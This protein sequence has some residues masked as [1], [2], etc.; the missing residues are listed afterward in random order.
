MLLGER[1]LDEP[2]LDLFVL[3]TAQ[4]DAT[5]GLE[6]TARAADLL[7][8]GDG[9][10][11]RL[12]VDDEAEVGFVV[13]HPE[14]SGRDERLDLVGLEFAFGFDAGLVVERSEVG[15]DL[16]ALRREPGRHVLD[17]AHGEAVD[18]AGAVELGE[19][20]GEPG[21]A[22]GL[23]VEADRAERETLTAQRSAERGEL[24]AELVGH[25]VDDAVVGRGG[26]AEDRHR[27]SGEAVDDA[28]DAA[29]VGP[30]VVAP[31]GDAVHL[32]DHDQPRPGTDDRHDLVA[33]LRVGEPLGRDQQQVDLVGAQL[34][35]EFGHGGGRCAVDRLAAQPEPAGRVDLVAH[36]RQQ[37]R[38][39]QRRA[40]ALRTQEM[41]GE[42][43]D[44]ALAPPGAL[45]H[46]HPPAVVDERRDR[47]ALSVTEVGVG[48][49]G[50][51]AERF[52]QWVG[53]RHALHHGGG[54]SRSS[55]GHPRPSPIRAVR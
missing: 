9:R 17:V 36:Q 31:V 21:E 12:E 13:A 26:A 46:E 15:L 45:H 40:G 22:F 11:G 18:D 49:P 27:R 43:V 47:F 28:P 4:Q 32:I 44:G 50:Q 37:R 24:G 52:E 23:A 33:E 6:C 19:R 3:L 39:Q 48:P 41:G 10:A 14:G 42:E 1:L 5:A 53:F 30:E 25:V 35:F 2:V 7:V 51:R 55:R 38:D 54:V 29:V 16:D 20:V 34:S 8:V